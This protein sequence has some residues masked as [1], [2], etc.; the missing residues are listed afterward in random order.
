[1]KRCEQS[2]YL[3]V[4]E[5]YSHCHQAWNNL[6]IHKWKGTAWGLYMF[7]AMKLGGG[8]DGWII[9]PKHMYDLIPEPS[10]MSFYRVTET[11][12][13][14]LGILTRKWGKISWGSRDA[15]SVEEDHEQN[16]GRL[17]KMEN[18]RE[19]IFPWS[20]ETEHSSACKLE[21][22]KNPV[23]V[24]MS[25]TVRERV[26]ILLGYWESGFL[27]TFSKCKSFTF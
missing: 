16:T 19:Q 12:H 25:R 1:M 15:L 5:V 24:P 3:C 23:G 26:C 10:N 13:K 4:S 21:S 8:V 22:L 11:L 14:C 20:L 2:I 27:L 7:H 9:V 6:C 18:M 17:D